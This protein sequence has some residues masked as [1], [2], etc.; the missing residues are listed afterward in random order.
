MEERAAAVVCVYR[1]P[2]VSVAT[3]AAAP[4]PSPLAL[5]RTYQTSK[6]GRDHDEK[7]SLNPRENITSAQVAGCRCRWLCSSRIRPPRL[8]DS[9]GDS[10]VLIGQRGGAGA[11]SGPAGLMKYG[12]AEREAARAEQET[13]RQEARVSEFRAERARASYVNNR[14]LG[15]QRS[16]NRLSSGASGHSAV[17]SCPSLSSDRCQA[18]ARPGDILST[19][20]TELLAGYWLACLNSG[21]IVRTG[22]RSL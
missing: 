16:T 8:Q 1:C 5:T 19:Q 11:A 13:E 9:C 4:C 17:T 21:P 12:W 20:L 14:L 3:T 22:T 6:P 10:S 15:M 18:T 2:P 7:L